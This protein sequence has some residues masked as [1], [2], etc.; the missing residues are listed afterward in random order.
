MLSLALVGVLA[1]G[2]RLS[3]QSAPSPQPLPHLLDVGDA[4]ALVRYSPGSLDRASHLQT[5]L[6]LLSEDFR[7]W[8]G[9]SIPLGAVLLSRAEWESVEL[10]VPY[11]LA[12]RLGNGEVALSAW[13][14]IGTVR[15][16]RGL[17]GGRLPELEGHPLHGTKDEAASLLLA[18]VLAQGIASRSLLERAGYAG[19]HPVVL[20][21]AAHVVSLAASNRH[22][23]MTLGEIRRMYA[24]QLPSSAARAD[25]WS[26]RLATEGAYFRAADALIQKRGT[27]KA[28]K[29]VLKQLRKHG[30]LLTPE[31]LVAKFPEAGSLLS[32]G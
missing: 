2:L 32:G 24:R 6:A 22:E 20:N 17:L 18:D 8:T 4:R 25:Q 7:R 15:L 26:A 30:L 5:R 14:D 23:P 11:G 1:S 28:V 27:G 9:E 12:A 16:W 29:S 13:G 19:I 31:A 3:A 21:F 10:A